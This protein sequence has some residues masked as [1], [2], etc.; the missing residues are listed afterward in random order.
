MQKKSFF[1][2]LL[3]FALQQLPLAALTEIHGSV[4][5]LVK[6]EGEVL[7]EL[8]VSFVQQRNQWIVDHNPRFSAGSLCCGALT[9]DSLS[10]VIRAQEAS[11]EAIV[12]GLLVHD[13]S[14]FGQVGVKE[15]AECRSFTY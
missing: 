12:C 13:S 14:V 7:H 6:V 11:R 4:A 1:T 9:R 10:A 2:E 15:E 3:R 5:A 8:V